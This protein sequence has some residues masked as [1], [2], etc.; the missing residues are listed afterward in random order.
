M[1]HFGALASERL[2]LV[3]KRLRFLGPKALPVV[4]QTWKTHELEPKKQ[5]WH[6]SW[7]RNGFTVQLHN[8]T[9]CLSDI[10]RLAEQV[11]R[12]S[13]VDVYQSLTPVQRA[14]FWRYAITYLEGGVYSD[15][16]IAATP[17]TTKFFLNL[18]QDKTDLVSE[19]AS[20]PAI[21]TDPP[22]H[23]DHA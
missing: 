10:Q 1:A 6:M 12:P 4:H 5:A 3:A 19:R 20:Q 18:D 15:I 7:R 2:D 23:T 17:E 11:D 13:L 16:D 14:D 22:A 21:H 8:D 9:E